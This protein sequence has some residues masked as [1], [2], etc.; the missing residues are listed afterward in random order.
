MLAVLCH[1]MGKITTTFKSE[2]GVYH[3]WSHEVAGV[4]I[5][6]RFLTRFTDDLFIHAAVK[7]MVRY[8]LL[9]G[10]LVKQNATARAYKRLAYKLA[11]HLTMELLGYVG[12][13]DIR[14]RNGKRGTPLSNNDEIC[15][16]SFSSY[17]KAAQEAGV[18]YGYEEPVLKGRDLLDVMAPNKKFKSI[19]DKAYEIQLE[20]GITDKE[21]LKKRVL[22]N[23]ELQKK[24]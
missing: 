23:E 22:T 11:P 2:D 20:E 9:P 19:L 16:L 24:R 10:Q 15:N 12:L 8:H 21:H 5:A 17:K 1:D 3:A 6:Q 7:K 4:E 18:L 14:G 13:S